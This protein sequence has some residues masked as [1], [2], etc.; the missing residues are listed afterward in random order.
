MSTTLR[1]MAVWSMAAARV[2]DRRTE[3]RDRRGRAP[4][5]LGRRRLGP[6]AAGDPGRRVWFGYPVHIVE[7]HDDALV[8]YVGPGAELA[9]VAGTWPTATGV[10]PW[11]DRV[12]WEGHGCLM[13]QRPDDLFAVWHCWH[14][15]DRR[16]L[17]WCINFEA[18]SHRTAI[19]YLHH[20]TGHQPRHPPRQRQ[21]GWFGGT[22]EHF[23][24]GRQEWF[25]T[26]ARLP[27]GSAMTTGEPDV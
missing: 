24:S 5:H 19:G 12:R 22:V 7:D 1:R 15:P 6:A 23:S 10:H 4:V 21:A 25:D 27:A 2:G 26:R 11:R 14:G 16:F 8:S 3:G 17:C 9:F 13:V 20:L 18:P